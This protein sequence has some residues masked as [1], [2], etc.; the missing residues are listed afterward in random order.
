MMGSKA[1]FDWR[2]NELKAQTHAKIFFTLFSLQFFRPGGT[3]LIFG[4]SLYLPLPVVSMGFQ[5]QTPHPMQW[6]K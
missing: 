3:E 5:A 1:M 2:C 6:M 4:S